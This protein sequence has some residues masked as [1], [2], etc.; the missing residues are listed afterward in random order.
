MFTGDQDARRAE[1]LEDCAVLGIPPEALPP[2]HDP[3]GIW[4]QNLPALEAFLDVATQF[5]R[6]ALADGR[7]RTTGLN[8]A[9][10][11]AAWD[12]AGIE[13]TPGLFG[14]IQVIEHAAVAEWNR[15]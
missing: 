12:L 3:D 1:E 2:A 4:H 5:S 15:T 6:F 8:Y 11:R 9:S 13:I 14:Q 10:A 7:T